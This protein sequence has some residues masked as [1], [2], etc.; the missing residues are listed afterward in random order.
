[1]KPCKISQYSTNSN[2][3]A[4]IW[5]DGVQRYHHVVVCEQAHGICPSGM[6]ASHL[7][8][9]KNCIEEEHL[10]WETSKQNNARK[11]KDAHQKSAIAGA[12]A[13]AAA[14]KKRARGWVLTDKR[15]K[16]YRAV[17]RKKFLGYFGTEE[18]AH[19]AYLK[20]GDQ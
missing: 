3:Y 7:C 9:I 20:A 2:G 18:E 6:Q 17:Y 8:N 12:T 11:S 1:M 19:A 5:I 14:K 16:P 15:S 4:T 10:V 13:S